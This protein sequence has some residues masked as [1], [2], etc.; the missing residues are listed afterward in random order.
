MSQ[1]S[2]YKIFSELGS[3]S[4]D[5]RTVQHGQM[6]F[7]LKGE[8]FDGN[9]YVG[10]ALEQGASYCIVSDPDIPEDPRIIHVQDTMIAL[11]QLASDYRNDFKIPFIAITGSNG[12]TTT[13]EL[14]AH[15]L[16]PGYKIHMTKGNLN[17]HLGVPLTLLSM[18]PDTEL[19][20]IEM[21]AN[22]QQEIM[23]LCHIAKPTH[24]VITNIGQAHLGGFGGL[25][26]VKKAKSELLDYLESTGGVQFVNRNE[27]S[28]DFV[29]KE[30]YHFL[31]EY[32]INDHPAVH[33]H[34]GGIF[35]ELKVSN[36]IYP[37]Q[38]IGSYNFNNALTAYR[39][40]QYFN[41][42][43]KDLINGMISYEPANNR[44]QIVNFECARIILDA[45]NAN[46]SSVR[47]AIE[48]IGRHNAQP[49]SLILGDMMELGEDSRELH[50]EVLKQV[51]SI[52][53]WDQ[54]ILVGT[55]YASLAN[56]FPEYRFYTTTQETARQLDW[57]QFKGQI[58]LLKGS[59][60]IGLE[61]LLRK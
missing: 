12:K 22:H 48:N 51:Q 59:R 19:A 49:R 9:K 17:N 46:P 56:V 18:P 29:T 30:N 25:E 60:S 28:L 53:G 35:L 15:C 11:Q 52:A 38:L 36:H 55:N 23:E 33:N 3:V 42:A 5:S 47:L 31:Q 14:M 7:A 16:R 41:I 58:I 34:E 43:E 54:V 20:I 21:G 8:N 27:P 26:G 2:I 40:G 6:F 39:I 4:I 13:K 61:T 32:G 10:Q 57:R 1:K 45:Y 44:S 24:G 37:T 50:H